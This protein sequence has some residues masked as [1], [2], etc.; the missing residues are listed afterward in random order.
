MS[1]ESFPEES[2]HGKSVSIVM[3]SGDYDKVIA[4]FHIATAAATMGAQV[5]I[6]FTFWGLNA[7]RKGLTPLPK[8]DIIQ[9]LFGMLS[10]A[11]VSKLPL[12]RLN[13]MGIGRRLLDVEMRRKKTPGLDELIEMARSLGV[14]M[15]ACTMSMGVMGVSKDDFIDGVEKF[16]GAA[17]YFQNASESDVN[18]FI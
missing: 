10:K 14:E 12:S 1:T 17:T 5:S 9:K 2:N 3:F 7:I 4:A 16:A 13:F 18:L 6:F 8:R 15:I 11:G